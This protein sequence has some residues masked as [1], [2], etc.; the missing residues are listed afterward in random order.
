MGE[1]TMNTLV[2]RRKHRGSDL[3]TF[4]ESMQDLFGRFFGEWEHPNVGLLAPLDIAEDES[5]F[6]LKIDLPGVTANDIDIQVHDNRLTLTGRREDSSEESGMNYYHV[7]RRSGSFRREVVLPTA[8]DEE[9]IEAH[10][11]DGVLTVRLPKSERAKPRKIEVQ[12]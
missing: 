6:T 7:E 8:V 1:T 3:A 9:N 5:G 2:K 12:P 11:T 4:P 10:H